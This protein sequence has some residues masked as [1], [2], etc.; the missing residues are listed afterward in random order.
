MPKSPFDL[1]DGF[2]M[3]AVSVPTQAVKQAAGA[4]IKQ[5]AQQAKQATQAFISQLYGGAGDTSVIADDQKTDAVINPLVQA[6]KI[7][8]GQVGANQHSGQP[9]QTTATTEEQAK[10]EKTRRELQQTHTSSYATPT[11]GRI[12]NLEADIKKEEEKRK[13]EEQKRKQEE[14]EEE[15]RKLQEKQ[16]QNQEFSAPVG[17]GGRNRMA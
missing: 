8:A 12:D 5:T 1:D 11:L 13:Q 15:Q 3:P 9:T 2:E 4:V 16:Q 7:Q 14:L 6:Q 10:I 17:K